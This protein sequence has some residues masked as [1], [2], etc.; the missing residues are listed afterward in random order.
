[1]SGWWALAGAVGLLMWI[2]VVEA[3]Y[4]FT[5]RLATQWVARARP[6]GRGAGPVSLAISAAALVAFAVSGKSGQG[7]AT[8]LGHP[9]WA[10]TITLPAML[11][12]APFVGATAPL[13]TT[14][15][16]S[17][18]N[19]LSSVGATPAEERR[20]AWWAGPPSLLGTGAIF[21]SLMST[22]AN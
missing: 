21:L 8:E 14:A 18:R 1:M 2:F 16:G 9:L 11:M 19:D 15:Y 7:L 22:F 12:Y 10:L 6:L 3:R 5:E 4:D 13:G 17:W 20:I